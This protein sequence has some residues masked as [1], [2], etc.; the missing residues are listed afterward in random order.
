M[1]QEKLIYLQK[2]KLKILPGT[3]RLSQTSHRADRGGTNQMTHR[4]EDTD[5]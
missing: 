1:Y 5:A 4:T 2:C 3:E